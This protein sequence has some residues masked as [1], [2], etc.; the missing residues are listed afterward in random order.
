[1]IIFKGKLPNSSFNVRVRLGQ[2]VMIL[3]FEDNWSHLGLLDLEIIW[4][5]YLLEKLVSELTK[6]LC[7]KN[8]EKHTSTCLLRT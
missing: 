6:K 5:P 8:E 1:M 3:K 2:Y 7:N 4:R